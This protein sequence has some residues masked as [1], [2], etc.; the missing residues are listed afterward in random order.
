MMSDLYIPKL[1]QGQRLVRDEHGNH[2]K[3]VEAE[4]GARLTV[5]PQM[6]DS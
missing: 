5:P 6:E 4:D 2:E 1:E 3:M